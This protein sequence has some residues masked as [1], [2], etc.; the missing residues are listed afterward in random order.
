MSYDTWSIKRLEGKLQDLT[1]KRA[2]LKAEAQ[3]VHA[4]LDRAQAAQAA[5]ERVASMSDVERAALAQA[6]AANGIESG[7]AVGTPGGG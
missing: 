1:E 4:A 3:E 7:E 6:I 2:A 5:E